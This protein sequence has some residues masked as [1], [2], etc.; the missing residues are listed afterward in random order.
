[1]SDWTVEVRPVPVEL[2][3]AFGHAD[4]MPQPSVSDRMGAT[5]IMGRLDEA[6][7]AQLLAFG[8]QVI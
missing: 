4:F 2:E 1:M 5:S 8:R 3:V 6:T 7:A